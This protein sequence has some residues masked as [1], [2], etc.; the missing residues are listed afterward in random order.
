MLDVGSPFLFGEQG[1][2]DVVPDPSFAQNGW[3][4]VFYTKGNPGQQ[5][6]ARASRFTASGNGTVA[7][8]EVVLWEDDR[9][10]ASDHQGGAIAVGG[11]GKVYISVGDHLTGADAQLLSNFHGKILRVNKDGTV[12]TDNPFFDGAGP[13]KDAIWARGLRNPFRMSFDAGTGR[14]YIG[15]VGGN[16]HSVAMEEVNIGTPGANYGWPMCEGSCGCPGT[17][18]PLYSYAHA[19]RDAS[20][21]GGFVYHGTQFPAEY[22][23]SYFFGDYAKNTINRLRLGPNGELLG[24]SNF[25]PADGASDTETVGD[26]VDLVEGPDGSLYYIDIGFNESHEPNGSAIRRI[27]YTIGNQPPTA[28]ASASPTSGQ[29]PLTVQ[30]SSA[31]SLDPEGSALSYSWTFGDGTTSTAANPSHTYTAS[32][33]YTARLSVSDGVNSTLSAGIPIAVGEPARSHHLSANIGLD[34]P[35]RRSNQLRG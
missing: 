32:G 17:T 7:G 2:Y 12:P 19:N 20:I 9:N 22:R 18:G 25:W 13:N 8:S 14:L 3:Y 6:R 31:G 35:R 1:V 4:Y 26:P 10:S 16:D 11:D 15:D 33:G 29:P 30:F 27:R 21:T 23:G 5:N 28:V 34:I 24:A